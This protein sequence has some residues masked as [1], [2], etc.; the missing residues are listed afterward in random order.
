MPRPSLKDQRSEQILDAYLTCVSRFGLEGATQERVATE[1]GVKR[2]ILRHYLGNKDEM[3]GALISHVVDRFAQATTALQDA[4][5]PTGTTVDLIDLLFDKS[6][7]N[8]PRVMLAYQSLVTSVANH[9]SMRQPLVDSL[10][11]FFEVIEAV[12]KRAFP[13]A[14]AAQIRAVSQGISA[15]YVNLDS[16][17]PLNPPEVWR[18]ELKQAATI[19][20]ASLEATA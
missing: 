14:P 18:A 16:L 8:D 11:Q 12:L 1:A 20:A 3:T 13:N 19:L 10:E 6:V 5:E 15:T 2:P 4:L 7:P 9:P 17:T